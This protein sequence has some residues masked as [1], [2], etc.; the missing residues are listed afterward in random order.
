MF[1]LAIDTSTTT[2]GCV[3]LEEEDIR[4][5]IIINLGLNHSATLLPSIN[6]LI[7]LAGMKMM[8]IDLYACT[9]G[10]GSFTGLRI[11]A[12]TVKGFAMATGKPAVGVSALDALA[13]NIT[14]SSMLICPMLDAKKKQV[15]TALYRANHQNHIERVSAEKAIEVEKMLSEIHE[16]CIFFGD[17]ASVYR[18][19]IKEALPDHA[20]F[21]LPVHQHI[22]AACVGLLG[23]RQFKTGNVL[24][25]FNFTPR[26][27]RASE[28]EV[29][30]QKE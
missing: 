8:D 22:R 9:V 6:H 10:P 11:G 24:D 16:D 1:T 27:L 18:D 29:K 20:Y 12:S 2:A 23:I 5:E 17:G 21:T 13:F 3:L 25:L 26:Y 15:Y 30:I 4:A 28:A 14:N 7:G 19:A